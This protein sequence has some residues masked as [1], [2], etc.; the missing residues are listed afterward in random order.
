MHFSIN[1]LYCKSIPIFY[2]HF[3]IPKEISQY[4]VPDNERVLMKSGKE[5]RHKEKVKVVSKTASLRN[6][7]VDLI[8]ILYLCSSYNNALCKGIHSIIKKCLRTKMLLK[9]I[10][11]VE[12][13]LCIYT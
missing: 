13:H 3:C 4:I 8:V 6:K 12:F 10:H 9:P 1:G 5:I 7:D 2:L 11:S